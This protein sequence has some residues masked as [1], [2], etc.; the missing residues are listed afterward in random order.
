M[1]DVLQIRLH[2]AR[3]RD[4]GEIT[5]LDRGFRSLRRRAELL[6]LFPVARAV[7]G[8]GDGDPDLVLRSGKE[9]QGDQPRA[10]IGP[11]AVYT[12]VAGAALGAGRAP[13]AGRRARSVQ[14]A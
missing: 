7:A 14:Q 2:G 10:G 4:L 6:L 1:N 12:R 5:Q 9:A 3:L 13:P 8:G 11:E